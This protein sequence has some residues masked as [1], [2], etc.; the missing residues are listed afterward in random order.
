MRSPAPIASRFWAKV[1]K[2][3]GCWLWTGF[4]MKNGYGTM[5]AGSRSQGKVL[6]HRLSY[7]L[8]VGAIPEGKM[9]LHKCDTRNCVRPG[10]LFLGTAKIN[11]EDMVAKGRQARREKILSGRRSFAGELNPSARLRSADVEEIRRL[12]SQGLMSQAQ[13]SQNFGVHIATISD[14]VLGKTWKGKEVVA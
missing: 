8:N 5:G 4:C 9:V 7:E 10:H 13:L 12:N 11:S 3:N 2:T 14:I 6:V 1:K